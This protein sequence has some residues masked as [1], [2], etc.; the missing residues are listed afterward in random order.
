[1]YIKLAILV[2]AWRIVLRDLNL[3]RRLLQELCL[4]INT[5][6]DIFRAVNVE[7]KGNPYH[8]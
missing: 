5:R 6:V 2:I 1:M 3:L 7:L 4:K 8:Q